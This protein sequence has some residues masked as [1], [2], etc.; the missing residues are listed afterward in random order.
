ME[1]KRNA[2]YFFLSTITSDQAGCPRFG[3]SSKL[4]SLQLETF[5]FTT[6]E[7]VCSGIFRGQSCVIFVFGQEKLLLMKI[8]G[9]RVNINGNLYKESLNKLYQAIR[10]KSSS[11]N[12]SCGVF[13]LYFIPQ[14]VRTNTQ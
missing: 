8:K 9:P 11:G 1:Y 4:S 14:Y 12:L 2:N 6:T 10:L 5:K 7:G 13:V 3:P